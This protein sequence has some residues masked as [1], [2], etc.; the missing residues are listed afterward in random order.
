LKFV[1]KM[2]QS[3]GNQLTNL[4]P[5]PSSEWNALAMQNFA[6]TRERSDGE[7]GPAEVDAGY[8]HVERK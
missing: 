6:V 1:S 8:G 2:R 5:F 3:L 7:L 4:R